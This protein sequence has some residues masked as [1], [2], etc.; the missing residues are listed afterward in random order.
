VT[1]DSGDGMSSFGLLAILHFVE[2]S[3]IRLERGLEG[4]DDVLDFPDSKPESKE[5][6]EGQMSGRRLDI[7][8]LPRELPEILENNSIH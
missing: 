5:L 3:D 6:L 7:L 2:A 8:T 1:V 4:P